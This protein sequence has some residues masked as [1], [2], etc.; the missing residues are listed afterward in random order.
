MKQTLQK[1]KQ[2]L[3]SIMKPLT[4]L[5]AYISTKL[6]Q[7]TQSGKLYRMGYMDAIRGYPLIASKHS[8]SRSYNNGYN[9]GLGDNNH[10]YTY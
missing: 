9:A 7:S 2:R 8:K 5:T 3:L 6:I 1:L 10:P 4:S